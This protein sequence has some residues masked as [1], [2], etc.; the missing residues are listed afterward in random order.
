M[1]KL[2]QKVT[3]SPTFPDPD[4]LTRRGMQVDSEID[5]LLDRMTKKKRMLEL[6]DQKQKMDLLETFLIKTRQEKEQL[7]LQLQRELQYI[8]TDLS[9]V[10][11][12]KVP[13]QEIVKKRRINDDNAEAVVIDHSRIH[14]YLDD[15]QAFYFNQ[16]CLG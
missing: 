11:K 16:R 9:I 4:Q 15:L 13:A 1:D 3:Q 10:E 6:Q 12:C 14:H 2:I 7:L 5:F 8:V